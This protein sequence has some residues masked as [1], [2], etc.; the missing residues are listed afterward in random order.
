MYDKLGVIGE[1]LDE[2]HKHISATHAN[3]QALY[4]RTARRYTHE[5]PDAFNEQQGMKSYY[6]QTNRISNEP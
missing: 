1:Q 6:E 5:Q 2:I 4:T 3:S